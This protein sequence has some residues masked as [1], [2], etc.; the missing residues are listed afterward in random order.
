MIN[1][2]FAKTIL[3]GPAVEV[4]LPTGS[5]LLEVSTEVSVSKLVG[6]DGKR[7]GHIQIVAT[8][9]IQYPVDETGPTVPVNILV[10]DGANI[11]IAEGFKFLNSF[12]LGPTK[13]FAFYRGL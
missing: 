1:R 9:L 2:V 4:H 8:A 13:L 6:A 5:S 11:V 3:E 12:M 10:T 7:E